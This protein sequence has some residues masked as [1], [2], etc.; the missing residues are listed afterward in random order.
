MPSRSFQKDVF[1]SPERIKRL[2]SQNNKRLIN[3]QLVTPGTR[4]YKVQSAAEILRKNNVLAAKPNSEYENT[5]EMAMSVLQALGI[6]TL[7]NQDRNHSFPKGQTN[8]LGLGEKQWGEVSTISS[9]NS[10]SLTAGGSGKDLRFGRLKNKKVSAIKSFKKL[11]N[12]FYNIDD[13]GTS[14]G[15]YMQQELIRKNKQSISRVNIA[16]AFN[17]ENIGNRNSMTLGQFK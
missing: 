14:R 12:P 4:S 15:K 16:A 5:H 3:G 7:E 1:E 8:T 17:D 6:S 9:S 10:L 11:E 2:K 13:A